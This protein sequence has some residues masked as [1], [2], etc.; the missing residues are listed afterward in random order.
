[1][2]DE[3]A[4]G[5]T[6]RLRVFLPPPGGKADRNEREGSTTDEEKKL[7]ARLA[8]HI[9]LVS[10]AVPVAIIIAFTVRSLLREIEWA[11]RV[12]FGVD[13]IIRSRM[14]ELV[15]LALGSLLVLA[16]LVSAIR[17]VLICRRLKGNP[18]ADAPSERAAG[19]GRERAVVSEAAGKDRYLSQLD[20]YLKN[21]II[22]RAE[23]RVLKERHRSRQ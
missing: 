1:M 14:P 18:R 23:Y 22:D 19:S 8:L 21:G 5:R 2:S 12:G 11:I 6:A 16:G 17:I 9:F 4:G 3:D 20:E 15:L 13:R 10:F 7:Q